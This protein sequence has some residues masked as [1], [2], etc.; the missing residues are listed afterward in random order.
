MLHPDFIAA[1]KAQL[2][3]LGVTPDDA[4]VARIA[5]EASVFGKLSYVSDPAGSPNLLPMEAANIA[6]AVRHVIGDRKPQN[7]QHDRSTPP[8]D[9]LIIGHDVGQWRQLPMTTRLRFIDASLDAAT[10]RGEDAG[11]QAARLAVAENRADLKQ[12]HAVADADR[13]LRMA[14]AAAPLT[15]ASS[16]AAAKADD[17]K[18]T[19]EIISANG[20]AL[21]RVSSDASVRKLAASGGVFAIKNARRDIETHRRTIADPTA[22]ANTKTYATELRNRAQQTLAKYGLS[23]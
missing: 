21:Q 13:A 16:R 20:D 22:N 1:V 15:R 10:K 9:L 19:A 6:A 3:A 4:E 12:Q 14:A 5:A 11:L 18:L 7:P 2:R 23:E 8:L 17:A